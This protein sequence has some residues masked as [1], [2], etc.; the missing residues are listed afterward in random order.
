MDFALSMYLVLKFFFG[1]LAQIHVRCSFG[2]NILFFFLLKA[3]PS[4]FCDDLSSCFYLAL[5]SPL[6]TFVNGMFPQA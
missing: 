4:I 6:V 5:I 2:S 1:A 3:W